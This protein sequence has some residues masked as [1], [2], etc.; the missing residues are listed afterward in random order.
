[1]RYS[2]LALWLSVAIAAT[3]WM[4]ESRHFAA[5]AE[6]AEAFFQGLQDRGLDDM[7]VLYLDAM[8]TS[9][10]CPPEFKQTI[11]YKAGV[12]LVN[13]A[14]AIRTTKERVK[15]LDAARARLDKFLAEHA[16]HELA[17]NATTQLANVLVER[18]RMLADEANASTKTPEEKQKLLDQTRGLYDEAKGVFAKAENH[19]VEMLKTMPTGLIDRKNTELIEKRS[20]VRADLVQSRLFLGT[21][22]YETA[23]TYAADSPERKKLLE[24]A[25]AKYKDLYEKYSAWL[26]GLYARMWEGRC[27]KELGDYNKAMQIFDELLA[28]VDEPAAFRQLKNKA[29]ILSLET[30]LLPA[31]KQYKTAIDNFTDWQKSARAAEQSSAD[32][33]AIKYLAACA[34]LEYARPLEE[35]DAKRGEA[36][37]AARDLLRFVSRFSGDYQRSADARLG[38]P[39]LGLKTAAE[40]EPTDFAGAQQR[41]RAALEQVQAAETRDN[42]ETSQGKSENHEKNLEEIARLRGEAIKF[43]QTA[44][45]LATPETPLDDLNIARYYLAYLYLSAGNEY[46]AAVLGEFLA[47]RYPQAAGARQ[48]AKI[49]MAAYAKMYNR[50]KPGDELQD[51]GNRHM[52][53]VAEY[54]TKCWPESPESADA[55]LMLLRTAV[56]GGN[57][58]AGGEILGKIPPGSNLLGEAE[59]MLGRAYWAEYLRALRLDESVRPAEEETAKNLDEARRLLAAGIEQSAAAAVDAPKFAAVLSLAQIHLRDG[60]ADEAVKLLDDEKIGAHALL[61]LKHP[62]AQQPG[63]DVETYKTALRAYVAVRDLDKAEKTMDVLEKAVA[64]EGDAE[65]AARLTQIYIGLGRELEELLQALRQQ[66]KEEQLQAVSEGF[67]LFLNRI[68]ERKQGNT[69]NSLSWVAETFFGMGSG[70]DSDGAALSPQAEKYYEKAADTY[71]TILKKCQ[72]D[73]SFAPRDDAADGV[74]IRLAKCLLRLGNYETAMKYLLGVLVRRNNMIDAQVQAAHTYQAWAAMPGNSAKYAGA[75]GGGYRSKKTGENVVWGWLKIS[76]MTAAAK[77]HAEIFHEAR[78][79]LALCQVESALTLSGQKKKNGLQIAENGITRLQL[80]YP[81]MGGPQWRPKYDALLK[82]IETLQGKPAVGLGKSS[83]EKK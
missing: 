82:K 36:I 59:M 37:A 19:Y 44:I 22:V 76:K 53:A 74:R 34:Y 39:L 67:E 27:Y 40:G 7:A 38:D 8:Q 80:L 24:E 81:D 33:L 60:K 52:T 31:V 69:F 4:A 6:P 83:G 56:A 49:A 5:A 3:A 79:N 55:W 73:K 43:F 28:Q 45:F 20:Q 17:S 11:D 26:A 13:G 16:D 23:M 15:Q 18:G 29:L 54:I 41:G 51:F 61:N 77:S 2:R 14:A 9:P 48:G 75:V 65:A 32:G 1:M 64:A 58:A 10:L 68:A 21:V 70:F 42:L 47:V 25:A 57:L 12:A 78:Y 63:Y 46:E 72:E 35:K 50:A 62:A 30:S 66:N 71:R